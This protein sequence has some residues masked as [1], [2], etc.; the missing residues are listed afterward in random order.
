MVVR[1]N[2]L[3]EGMVVLSLNGLGISWID[4]EEKGHFSQ[5]TPVFGT[6]YKL[7]SVEWRR[8]RGRCTRAGTSVI[9]T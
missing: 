6:G 5:R 2:I 1:K 3:E 8:E 7:G 9:G 4:K